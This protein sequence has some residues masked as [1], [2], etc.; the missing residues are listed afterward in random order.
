MT[1]EVGEEGAM[2]RMRMVEG[3]QRDWN[4]RY[5]YEKLGYL[6]HEKDKIDSVSRN[7]LEGMV[8]CLQYYAA[9]CA[10]WEWFESK[11][12]SLLFYFLIVGSIPFTM[13]P[14]S[15]TSPNLSPLV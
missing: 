2:E 10:S 15:Q 9:G 12:I 4:G 3:D 7:F 5:Y 1:E 6:P 14:C 13:A 8:W 11:P